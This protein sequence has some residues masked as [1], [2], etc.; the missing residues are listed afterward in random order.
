MNKFSNTINKLKAK[1][2]R[3]NDILDVTPQWVSSRLR[4]LN[5][6]RTEVMKA[7]QIDKST[8]SLIMS[9]KRSMTKAMKGAFY[10]YL[11]YMEISEK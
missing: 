3:R 6:E 10:Y 9:G 4:D 1:T 7:L 8:F 2:K 5:L 11:A